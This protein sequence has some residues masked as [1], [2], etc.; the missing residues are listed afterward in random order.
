V[1]F[2]AGKKPEALLERLVTCFSDRG[3]WVLDAFAGSGTTGAVAHKLGRRWIM[4]EQAEQCLTH[5]LPRMRSVVDGADATGITASARWQ[6]GGGF[7]F[8]EVKPAAGRQCPSAA[9]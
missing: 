1:E 9:Q 3:D 8:F 6:G 7:R 2:R 5:V 4:I